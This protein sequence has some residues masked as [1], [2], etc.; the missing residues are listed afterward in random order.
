MITLYCPKCIFFQFSLLAFTW[1]YEQHSSVGCTVNRPKLSCEIKCCD[2]F[3]MHVQE[4]FEKLSKGS[5]SFVYKFNSL[6]ITFSVLKTWIAVIKRWIGWPLVSVGIIFLFVRWYTCIRFLSFMLFFPSF[7]RHDFCLCLVEISMI[8]M[9]EYLLRITK[10]KQQETH[11]Q[12]LFWYERLAKA[13]KREKKSENGDVKIRLVHVSL[14]DS[15][16]LCVYEWVSFCFQF[17]S[18]PRSFYSCLQ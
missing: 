5:F 17:F 10:K 4:I 7:F 1:I 12:T 14:F 15:N 16:K 8:L 6:R 13:K 9:H 11:T 2:W 3:N 18:S